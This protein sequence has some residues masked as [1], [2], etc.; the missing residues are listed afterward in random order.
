MGEE[1][2]VISP[3]GT[4]RSRHPEALGGNMLWS[5]DSRA[6]LRSMIMLYAG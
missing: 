6:E 5:L 3:Q 4:M 1:E 2:R